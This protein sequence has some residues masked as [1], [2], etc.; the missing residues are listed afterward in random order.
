MN[1]EIQQAVMALTRARSAVALTGAGI[2][3]ESGIPPF[4]GKGGLWEKIDPMK[5]AHIDAFKRNPGQVWDVLFMGLN[6]ALK[7]A[8]P[9]DGHIGLSKLESMGL[10]QTIVTQNIDGLH[11]QAGSKD[12]IEF[13]GSFASQH[14]M[15]CGRS[16]ES[17]KVCLKQLPPKCRCGG[18]LRPDVV[19]FGEVIPS[20]HMQRAQM[21]AANCDVMMVVG[22][23]A[24]VEPAAYLPI[25]AKR[26]GATIIEINP[27][28]TPL[29]HQ[30]SDIVLLGQAGRVM[31]E[32][33]ETVKNIHAGKRALEY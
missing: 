23:S 7:N 32:L 31:R 24:T 25:I 28:A 14:C 27:E 3:V 30:V 9:N 20:D 11:Q 17:R 8:E 5:Y 33:M 21:L 6:D 2:S 19:M 15:E 10:V 4:R 29:T 26:A 22:T 12:V 18:I 16:V 13:H 1:S